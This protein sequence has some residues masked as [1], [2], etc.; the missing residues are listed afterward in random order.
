M[1][2]DANYFFDEGLR[3][4]EES[5][6]DEALDNYLRAAA[7]DYDNPSCY[8]NI[9]LIYKY[10]NN[11]E[12]SFKFNKIA[13]DIDPDDEAC[14]WNYAIAATAL[15]NWA[16]A[17]KAWS[18]NG[19]KIEGDIGPIEMDFGVTPVRLNPEGDA[20]VVWAKRIDPVRA[21][22]TSIPMHESGFHYLDIVLND[23]APVGTRVV[24]DN[25]Y[26]VFNVLE[27][28]EPSKYLTFVSEVELKDQATSERLIE[29]LEEENIVNED[30]TDNFRI[31][32]KACSEGTPHEHKEGEEVETL[33]EWNSIHDIAI[34]TLNVDESIDKLINAAD[35]VGAKIIEI[36][37]AE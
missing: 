13:Y 15:R 4:S 11:W 10:K 29:I 12:E 20:E 30:W 33:K 35:K 14:R 34:A 28:F 19:L 16:A 7:L 36:Y 25:E 9:G 21:T 1:E 24:D 18:D 5:K 31:L 23:G 32:C 26:S 37:K 6:E 2:N 22:I 27:L 3:L 17:R 8:Y